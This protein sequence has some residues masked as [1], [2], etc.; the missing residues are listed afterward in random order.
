MSVARQFANQKCVSLET[1][2]ADGTPVRTTVWVLEESGT[3]YIRTGPKTGK[4]KRIR[5]NPHVRLASSDMNGK[6]TGSWAGGEAQIQDG[7]DS[8]RIL[9]LFRKKYGMTGRLIEFFNEL[10]GRRATVVIAVKL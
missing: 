4:V 9:G 10:R 3:L 8:A 5:K 6:V 2:R 1:Y 7:A